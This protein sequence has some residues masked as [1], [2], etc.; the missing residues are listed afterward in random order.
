[1][2]ADDLSVGLS[3]LLHQA[4]D[5]LPPKFL[6]AA[7]DID[8]KDHAGTMGELLQVM[9]LV[10]HA[11]CEEYGPLAH[12]EAPWAEGMW[13]R[14]DIRVWVFEEN[15]E[16]EDD[17][18]WPYDDKEW[19]ESSLGLASRAY[20]QECGWDFAPGES[21]AWAVAYLASSWVG[22]SDRKDGWCSGNLAGFAVLH[23]RDEDDEIESL[24]HLWTARQ[25]RRQ[26][27]ARAILKRAQERFSL[28]HVEQPLTD[29]GE[30][31][32]RAVAPELLEETARK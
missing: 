11:Y 23:D 2:P 22:G 31:L 1:M 10:E 16:C 17:E 19:R 28:R 7:D 8:P 27:I 15:V 32:L 5:L 14:P 29:D 26:G 21:G 13:D 12:W 4:A 25:Y 24:A 9:K 18:I 6:T 30:A 20:R 3:Q